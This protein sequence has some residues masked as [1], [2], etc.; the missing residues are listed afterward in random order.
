MDRSSKAV[1][2]AVDDAKERRELAQLRAQYYVA[3]IRA[4]AGPD[5]NRKDRTY[6]DIVRVHEQVM[7]R[8]VERWNR[9]ELERALRRV[10]REW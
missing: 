5:G 3:C 2:G 9:E 10:K 6:V 8:P 1:R 4:A 7:G